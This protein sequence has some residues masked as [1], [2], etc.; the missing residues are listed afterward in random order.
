[1]LNDAALDAVTTYTQGLADNDRM[2]G[3]LRE[4]IDGRERPTAML[5]FGDHLPSFGVETYSQCGMFNPDGG[6]SQQ[7]LEAM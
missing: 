5:F 6:Y 2:L 1:V 4:Y 3:G 7:E